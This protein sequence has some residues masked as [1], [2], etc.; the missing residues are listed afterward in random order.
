MRHIVAKRV[1]AM[2]VCVLLAGCADLGIGPKQVAG[3]LGAGFGG[4]AG[5]TLGSKVGSGFGRTVATVGGASMGAL[6]GG[7]VARKLV[8]SDRWHIDRT[9]QT[10][11]ET[12]PTGVAKPW[13]NPDNG[14]TGNVVA[15]PA[16]LKDARPCRPF[17][18]TVE[19][20][21]RTE[22][23]NGHACRQPDGQW[24]IASAG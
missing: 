2:G 18:Q 4:L 15:G 23:A 20:D 19:I 8:D 21:G 13:R 17:E 6:F 16:A 11:L 1:M 22:R 12:A 14:R 9:T 10:A 3:A 5:G 24:Q 7:A